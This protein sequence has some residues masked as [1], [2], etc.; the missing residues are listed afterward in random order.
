M[1]GLSYLD[2]AT[3]LAEGKFC[4]QIQLEDGWLAGWLTVN[5]MIEFLCLQVATSLGEEKSNANPS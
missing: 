5:R 4:L 2:I 3:I 1:T